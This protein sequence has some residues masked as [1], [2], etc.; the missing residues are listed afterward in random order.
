MQTLDSG[1]AVFVPGPKPGVF[2]AQ[3]VKT[4]ETVDGLTQIT[5]GLRDGQPVVTK[6]AFLLKSQLGKDLARRLDTTL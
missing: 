3:P 6:N 5:Q 1:P 4:G 2:V